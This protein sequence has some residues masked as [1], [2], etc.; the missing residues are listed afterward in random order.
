MTAI[1]YDVDDQQLAALRAR[2]A[3]GRASRGRLSRDE[4]G[5]LTYFG[6]PVR[7]SSASVAHVWTPNG[8]VSI[9]RFEA[10]DGELEHLEDGLSAVRRDPSGLVASEFGEGPG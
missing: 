10:I 6:Y 1:A 8:W 4:A 3:A 2:F 7:V 5:R 9:A